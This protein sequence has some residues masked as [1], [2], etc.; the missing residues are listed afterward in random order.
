MKGLAPL[1]TFRTGSRLELGSLQLNGSDA[2]RLQE[3]GCL[4]GT[5][6]EILKS[7]NPMV[8]RIGETRLGIQQSLASQMFGRQLG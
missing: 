6:I 7:S 2:L 4:E 8:I 5:E 1:S 3:L